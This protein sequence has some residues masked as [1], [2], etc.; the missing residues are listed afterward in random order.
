[1]KR[2][3]GFTLLELL[4][5]TSLTVILLL[6]VSSVFMTFMLT[7]A[8]TNLR[9]QVQ[10]EGAEIISRMEF[11]I[12]NSKALTSCT[13]ASSIQFT[14]VEQGGGASNT[15]TLSQSGTDVRYQLD[16]ASGVGTPV[17]LN[18]PESKVN[19]L[20]F[21]C[22]EDA[23]TGKRVVIISFN[24]VRTDVGSSATESFKSYV[25]LRNS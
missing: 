14:T 15:I 18:S 19:S 24:L 8:R 4:V 21:A 17:V 12:R 1:M 16:T 2:K 6:G 9:R 7:E 25:Q 23:T 10:S 11:L 13:T 3:N 5:A 20:S 22:T